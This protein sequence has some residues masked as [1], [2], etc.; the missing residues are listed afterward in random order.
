MIISTLM[1]LLVYSILRYTRA[2]NDTLELCGA[3]FIWFGVVES[4]VYLL[5]LGDGLNWASDE[6]VT[7]CNDFMSCLWD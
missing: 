3:V 4:I 1:G 7:Y 5:I 2:C 6:V